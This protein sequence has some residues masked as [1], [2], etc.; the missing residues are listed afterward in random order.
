MRKIDRAY[1]KRVLGGVFPSGPR[2]SATLLNEA[3]GRVYLLGWQSLYQDF[4]HP[5]RTAEHYPAD[6]SE[7]HRSVTEWHDSVDR[8]R[9]GELEGCLI[10]QVPQDPTATDLQLERVLDGVFFGE[11]IETDGELWF[12]ADERRTLN[13]ARAPRQASA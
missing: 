10:L 8:I 7:Q 12:R 4:T 9:R 2:G 13:N 3:E 11:I 5:L 1:L 6:R